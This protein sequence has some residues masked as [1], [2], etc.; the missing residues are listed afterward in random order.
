MDLRYI[1]KETLHGN[2]VARIH[3][4]A[5]A[6]VFLVHMALG[7]PLPT[8]LCCPRGM[9]SVLLPLL[10]SPAVPL[11]LSCTYSVPGWNMWGCWSHMWSL[12]VCDPGQV[13]MAPNSSGCTCPQSSHISC[14]FFPKQAGGRG[15]VG[16]VPCA[17][18]LLPP[19]RGHRSYT[20]DDLH[21]QSCM[22][23]SCPDLECMPLGSALKW[24]AA[25]GFSSLPCLLH[26][27]SGW[28]AGESQRWLFNPGG[29]V[30]LENKCMLHALFL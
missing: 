26:S 8:G 25:C 20:K 19:G 12:A 18:F 15:A 30:G 6:L 3:L 11:V 5:E 2:K 4:W 14:P 9:S 23:P 1:S 28:A 29:G 24:S 17:S 22:G 16:N 10:L 7:P 27:G 13:R 21:G